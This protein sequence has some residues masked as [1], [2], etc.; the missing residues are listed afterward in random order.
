MSLQDRLT[1]LNADLATP[2]ACEIRGEGVACDFALKEGDEIPVLLTLEAS[3]ELGNEYTD[4]GG[5]FGPSPD[6]S[7]TEGT[8]S[9]QPALPSEAGALRPLCA[10][11]RGL[12]RNEGA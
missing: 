4:W 6:G 2:L 5:A 10:G 1:K 11:R 8:I 9:G 7:R 3:D 12:A